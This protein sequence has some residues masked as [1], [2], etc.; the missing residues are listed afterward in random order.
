[1]VYWIVAAFQLYLLMGLLYAITV[2]FNKGFTGVLQ[3]E[4]AVKIFIIYFLYVFFI[5]DV[6]K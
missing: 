2:G 3:Y 1:M 4:I 6:N 5:K